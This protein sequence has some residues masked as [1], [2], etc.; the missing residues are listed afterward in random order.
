MSD[1]PD[2]AVR[3]VLCY[4]LFMSGQSVWKIYLARSIIFHEYGARILDERR[5]RRRRYYRRSWLALTSCH[6]DDAVQGPLTERCKA[7]SVHKL[8]AVTVCA[9]A[10]RLPP[11]AEGRG[12][13]LTDHSS[14]PHSTPLDSRDWQLADDC[15]TRRISARAT[16]TRHGANTASSN[17]PHGPEPQ[18]Q[19]VETPRVMWQRF[20]REWPSDWARARVCESAVQSDKRC[21]GGP[22]RRIP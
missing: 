8:I 9:R 1:L 16:K 13:N 20:F 4:H 19:H 6:R 21:N 12:P 7:R 3:L 15:G 22:T 18:V 17:P 11:L 5:T 14:E 10:I 2:S